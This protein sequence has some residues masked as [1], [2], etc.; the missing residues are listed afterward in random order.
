MF[1]V[2]VATSSPAEAQSLRW[3]YTFGDSGSSNDFWIAAGQTATFDISRYITV[4]GSTTPVAC[5]DITLTLPSR[6]SSIS[7]SGCSYTVAAKSTSVSGVEEY[8]TLTICIQGT[9]FCAYNGRLRINF[10]PASNLAFTA[11]SGLT[12]GTNRTLAINAAS[13]ATESHARY[14]IS[15]RGCYE[16]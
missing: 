12:V 1:A 11:P 10:G 7:R 9:F 3:T 8:H 15:W 2:S 6:L 14:S 4:T 13:Y 5:P 16:H